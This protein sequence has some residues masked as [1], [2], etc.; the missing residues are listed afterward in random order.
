V[1][2]FTAYVVVAAAVDPAWVAARL[3]SWQ[4]A[5]VLLPAFLGELAA[6]VGRRVNAIDMIAVAPSRPGAAGIPLTERDSDHPRVLRA[7]RYRR[8]VRV[9]T[10]DGGVLVL[11]RGLC[12]RWEVAVEVEPAARGR[13]LGR[14]LARA[15]AHL[16]PADRAV[17]A[18]ISPGNAASVRALLAAGYRPVGVEALL[19]SHRSD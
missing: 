7:R 15:A 12:G 10:T 13:G 8:D 3:K 1:L 6:A 19:V 17:W 9:W 4:L 5:E 2:A 14:E 16:V 11:G 18:Q